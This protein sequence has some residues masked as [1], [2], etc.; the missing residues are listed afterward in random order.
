MR[1]ALNENPMVQLGVLLAMAV[2]FAVMLFSTVLKGDPPPPEEDPAT[3]AATAAP[4]TGVTPPVADDTSSAE[5]V[6]PAA[7]GEGAAF[8]PAPAGDAEKL[9]ATEGLPADVVRAYESNRAIALLVIDPE[10]LADRQLETWT[11]SL[12]RPGV[13]T[14]V[15][16]V[17]DIAEYARITQGV[18]V[19]SV[20]SLII[21][22]PRKLTD[23]VPTASVST[24]FEGP[25]S[26][27]QALED[28]LY[29]GKVRPPSEAH[30]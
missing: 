27:E 5:P 18:G 28:A 13:D 20:P 26:I 17:K 16:D 6:S 19:G 23:D 8:A 25:R 22:R 29:D 14:F 4:V 24:G 11:E 10:A 15:V 30:P 3:A 2:I 21:V 9:Q 12:N 1:K 7:S